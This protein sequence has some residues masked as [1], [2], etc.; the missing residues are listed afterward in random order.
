ME[1]ANK[2]R[3]CFVILRVLN[4][5]S[6]EPTFDVL[7]NPYDPST[8]GLYSIEEGGLRVRYRRSRV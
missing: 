1:V 3:T 8:K 2:K 5:L 4:A 7:P 6:T